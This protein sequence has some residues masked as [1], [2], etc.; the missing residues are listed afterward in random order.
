MHHWFARIT[1]YHPP[2]YNS[3]DFNISIA[4]I[5]T[6]I[7]LSSA[8]MSSISVCTRTILNMKSKSKKG[9]VQD[10]DAFSGRLEVYILFPQMPVK[11]KP[12]LTNAYTITTATNLSDTAVLRQ[13]M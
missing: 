1:P 9:L 13:K 5:E 7:K 11:S 6:F 4:H 2:E 3:R 8:E 12:H 10:P